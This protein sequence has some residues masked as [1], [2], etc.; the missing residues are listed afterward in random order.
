M[1]PGVWATLK[2]DVADAELVAVAH[3]LVLEGHA[4]RVVHM[5]R[6][7]R[8]RGQV[9]VAGDVVGVGVRLEDVGRS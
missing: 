1:W 5:D 7:P 3:V 9:A 4:G 2:L 6:R 8:R